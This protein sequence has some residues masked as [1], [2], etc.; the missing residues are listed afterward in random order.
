VDEKKLEGISDIRDESDKDGMRIVVELKRD[1]EAQ[2]ILNQLFKH[3]QLEGTFGIIML[4][5]VDNRPRVLTLKQMLEYYI[6]HR[7]IIIRRR[8]QFELDKALRRAH[9]LEGLKIALKYIE[10][11]I[12]TIKTSKS[13]DRQK[14]A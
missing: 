1:S 2:I 8:T 5:L 14:N 3:T 6:E 10:R 13:T 11:I 4:S 7:K 12:K 9:I